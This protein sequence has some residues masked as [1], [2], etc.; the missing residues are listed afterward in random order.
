MLTLLILRRALNHS[1]GSR[2]AFLF[3][4]SLSEDKSQVLG[5]AHD[6][7]RQGDM[8]LASHVF[9]A[10]HHCQPCGYEATVEPSSSRASCQEPPP[11]HSTSPVT[12]KVGNTFSLQATFQDP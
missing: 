9:E 5:K 3:R 1:V 2:S 6:F 4:H 8:Y 11:H 7:P 12:A 10:M